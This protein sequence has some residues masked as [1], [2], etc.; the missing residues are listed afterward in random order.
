MLVV[1]DAALLVVAE[2]HPAL[3]MFERLGAE[4]VMRDEQAAGRIFGAL[5]LAHVVPVGAA[6]V[7]H[8]LRARRLGDVEQIVALAAILLQY[9]HAVAAHH[10]ERHL[11][12]GDLAEVEIG[13]GDAA[14]EARI[15]LLLELGEIFFDDDVEQ[16]E[17]HLVLL[18]QL[19]LGRLGR[20]TKVRARGGAA[21]RRGGRL[22]G[23]GLAGDDADARGESAATGLA[24]DRHRLVAGG[25][26]AFGALGAQQL[27]D[28]ELRLPHRGGGA[29]LRAG[30]RQGGDEGAL[31]LRIPAVDALL[32]A[33]DGREIEQVAEIGEV[34]GA[35]DALGAAA[36][37]YDGNLVFLDSRNEPY[38]CAYRKMV[39]ARRREY[40]CG[41]APKRP[42]RS[43]SIKG[44]SA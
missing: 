15:A 21:P 14:G 43:L 1:E 38:R 44:N 32:L 7:V 5:G 23:G 29:A 25:A 11:Q 34:A 8:D 31:A 12:D 9:L 40:R 6:D 20:R 17:H 33:R 3:G 13:L 28:A 41:A 37:A 35:G 42:R 27:V 10:V 4:A 22:P 18:L 36:I 2:R 19:P 16:L 30:N 39:F 26:E 24:G